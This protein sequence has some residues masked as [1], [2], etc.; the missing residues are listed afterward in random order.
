MR[1]V[2]PETLCYVPTNESRDNVTWVSS[3]N[4]IAGVFLIAQSKP[5]AKTSAAL[6]VTEVVQSIGCSY[7][8]VTI[9]H[10]GYVIDVART[11]SNNALLLKVIVKDNDASGLL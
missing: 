10:L 6:T 11:R 1:L 9:A 5:L 3:E 7:D 8:D 2:I 4:I